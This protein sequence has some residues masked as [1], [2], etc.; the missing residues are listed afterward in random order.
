MRH[1]T[2][3]PQVLFQ[4]DE[5]FVHPHSFRSLRRSLGPSLHMLLMPVVLSSSARNARRRRPPSHTACAPM[6]GHRGSD[7]SSDVE[8]PS[9]P[10]NQRPTA[11][12][13]PDQP[14]P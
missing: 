8:W 13:A 7:L 9:W 1:E 2:F 10:G 14:P 4:M 5:A 11:P 3:V 12:P 6:A